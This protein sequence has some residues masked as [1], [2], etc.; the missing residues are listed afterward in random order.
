[1]IDHVFN[2]QSTTCWICRSDKI[3]S[4]EAQAF[5]APPKVTVNIKECKSCHFAWQY[6]RGRSIGESADWFENAYLDKSYTNCDYFDTEKK[7]EI[8]QLEADHVASLSTE[9]HVLL[10]IGAGSGIFAEVMAERGWH[11][12][13]V[14]PAMHE[15]RFENH[16][17]VKAIKGTLD[18]IPEGQLFDVI[19][20]WDVIEH[21]E[22]PLELIKSSM[23]YLKKGGW[24]VIE[25]GNYKSGV[26]VEGKK[27][28]WIY[29]LDHRWYFSPE[30]MNILLE[31]C[32]FKHIEILAKSLRPTWKGN[33]SY[34]WP[35]KVH[36]LKS[37]IKKP[38]SFP[39]YI[40]K[41]HKAMKW[42]YGGIGIFTI[43]AKN[44]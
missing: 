31:E 6:P 21:V 19:T 28:H 20:L 29:Q 30:S 27:R 26:R 23:K 7:R 16:T 1:M 10:D 24:L 5:D 17:T 12:T 36:L 25:T 35:S 9:K 42:E 15:E 2:E 14:D 18:D 22:S 44:V 11:V 37:M 3:R 39:G 4:F 13:A 38:F 33:V 34:V 41:L 40:R 32:G 43:S 8:A